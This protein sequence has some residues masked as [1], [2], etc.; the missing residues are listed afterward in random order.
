MKTLRP[1]VPVLATWMALS[2]GATLAAEALG[3]RVLRPVLG[4]TALAQTGTLAGVLGAL[5]FGAW[6]SGRLLAR[7]GHTPSTVLAR[8]HGVLAA[9]ALVASLA[10]ESAVLLAARL[11]VALSEVSPWLGDGA[12]LL[13]ALTVTAVP[14]ALA[15]SAYPAV[16]SLFARGAG[17]GTA[18]AGAS[19]SLGAAAAALVTTFVVCPSLGV[20]H[21]LTLVAALYALLAWTA[22]R[23]ESTASP[24]PVARRSTAPWDV[25][26]TG[27]LL[28]LGV[29]ST[30]W[31]V[32]LGRAASLA[33][34]PSAFAF[35]AALAA[36]V[37]ALAL[38]ELAALRAVSRAEGSSS[39]SALAVLTAVASVA[40][41]ASR[42]LLAAMPAWA[43]RLLEGG[44]PAQSTLW[45]SAY[46]ALVVGALPVVG[47]VGAA[48]GFAARAM[49]TDNDHTG[50]ANGRALGVMALGNVFG[51]L[52]MSFVAMPALGVERAAVAVGVVLAAGVAGAGRRGLAVALAAAMALAMGRA[53]DEGA[54]LR[55]PFL[56]AGSRD[57]ELGRLAWRRD[58]PEA[59][60]AVRRD[61]EGNVLLQIN[62]K[63]D[64]TSL[65]DQSTQT[66]VGL[67]PVAF[68]RDAR[69]V[70]VVGLGSGMTA[71]ASR[72]VPGVRSVEVAELVRGVIDAARGD[73]ARANH[74]VLEDR[75]VRVVRADAAHLLRGTSRS[76]DAIVS[77]PSNPWVAG[78]SDLFTREA[79]EAA[80]A[81][82]RPG[83]V[84]GAWFH[85][86]STSAEVVSSIAATFHAVFPEAALVEVTPGQDYLLLGVRDGRV[87][88]DT[89][90]RRLEDPTVQRLLRAANVSDAAAL[91]ARF[92]GGRRAVEAIAGDAPVLRASD[93]TLEFVAPSLLYRDATDEV[94]ARLARVDDLPLAGLVREMGPG[95]TW[96]R[97]VDESE[98]RREANTHL[99]AMVLAQRQGDLA[100]A[101]REGELA[102]GFDPRDLTARTLLARLYL[103]RA[104]QRT[105][106]RDRGGAEEDLTA[107]LEL[108][109]PDAE[110]F[111]ALVRLGDLAL[112]RR[113]GQRALSRFE[114]ALTLARASG[115]PAAELHVRMAEALAML[116][117]PTQAA[118][119]L[120]RAI[121]DT[122]DGRRREELE[123]LRA[124]VRSR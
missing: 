119:A 123:A 7:G 26:V 24:S 14:G 108:R 6:W 64:A 118:E 32:L 89:A 23:F 56:Y 29:A 60:V 120:D 33:F 109:P 4:S 83:G 65:G 40:A 82:L 116:G 18:M 12:R 58:E 106:R 5:G 1:T 78:M 77:E 57:V 53:P 37:T 8:S 99:R 98:A 11:F 10:P 88:L 15:G 41:L 104:A 48:M 59:T 67:L 115:E 121:R 22:S 47:A 21:T 76:Y 93:L 91:V 75:R 113:D 45:L 79:F 68:A 39:R 74:R 112:K 94:F 107:A 97:L 42:P 17:A 80:R 49:V 95:S 124:G 61:D 9:Y 44:A 51:A 105:S 101:L 85:A 16:V 20:A 92:V 3:A 36:H 117:A 46:G 87:D 114:E 111:R 35:A 2:G 86:Y 71:D 103:V 13:A 72:A 96:L 25:S 62:G 31:Q 90:L 43:E 69:D 50:E 66:V 70:L 110:R 19:S 28:A 27:A 100:R 102:V 38:G 30:A 81:R 84:F 52:A 63:V 54:M 55:G 73:F 34:G 122:R